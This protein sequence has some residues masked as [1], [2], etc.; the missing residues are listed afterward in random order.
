M[1]VEFDRAITAGAK[2]ITKKL[3]GGKYIHLALHKGKWIAGEVKE[4]KGK[5]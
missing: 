5:Q 4:K 1:P 3:K 2:V